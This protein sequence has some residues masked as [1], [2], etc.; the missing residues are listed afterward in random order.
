MESAR[1]TEQ[2]HGVSP[3]SRELPGSQVLREIGEIVPFSLRALLELRGAG[4]YF[5]E[6]LRQCGILI[7]GSTLIILLVPFLNGAVCGIFGTY[8]LRPLGAESFI[9][10]FT[11][12]CGQREAV[13]L[14]FSYMF[15][16][17][18]GCGLVAEIGS[19]RISEEIDAMESQGVSSMR[20][21]VATRLAAGLV[22]VPFAFVAALG[23]V[24]LGSY[25]VV[26]VQLGDV[27]LAGWGSVHWASQTVSD[28]LASLAKAVTIGTCILLVAC[29][30]GYRAR[31]GAVGVG[32][33]TARSMV[34]NLVLIHVIN[35][36]GSTLFF[37]DTSGLPFG[38]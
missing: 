19:M 25:L 24:S 17:K 27:S 28:N 38:G 16:A 22:Y 13:V 34:L 4:R 3:G 8:F 12:A 18:V 14:A 37:A 21:V 9:G 10:F 1:A 20:Y 36:I 6:T 32:A 26:V 7:T 31:G 2:E 5:G 33:A 15:A 30:Y 29:Y 23:V 35:A 11:T